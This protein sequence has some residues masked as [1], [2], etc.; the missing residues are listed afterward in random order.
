M[1]TVKTRTST[2]TAS[3][4]DR[5]LW[6]AYPIK[7]WLRCPEKIRKDTSYPPELKV[8]P[9]PAL[10]ARMEDGNIFEDAIGERFAFEADLG[11]YSLTMIDA[12]D[13]SE[14]GKR[15]IERASRAAI[16]AGVHVIWGARLT[17]RRRGLVGEPDV[18]V[19]TDWSEAASA[20]FSYYPV[21]VKHHRTMTGT[22]KAKEWRVSS[23][24]RPALADAEDVL[25]EGKPHQDDALQLAHYLPL[26]ASAGAQAPDAIGGIIGRDGQVVWMDLTQ[27]RYRR[28]TG[29]A[30]EQLNAV[31][32][33]AY[34]LDGARTAR[35]HELRRMAVGGEPLSSCEY[36]ACCAECPWREVCR[37]ELLEARHIT[38]IP[39]ITPAK[40]RAHY[41]A[42][43]T[44]F[45]DLAAL[46]HRTAVLVDAGVDLV[47]L[48]EAAK[49]V[50]ASTPVEVL[51]RSAEL[52]ALAAAGVTSA[53]D[54]ADLHVPT[55]RY[56]G[57]GVSG[58]PAAID[59][60]RARK[61]DRVLRVR[62]V[63]QLTLRRSV[64]EVD[65]DI[66]DANGVCYLIGVRESWRVGNETRRV[67][68]PFV[69][70]DPSREAQNFS[71]FWTY[72]TDLRTRV[73]SSKRGAFTAYVWSAHEERYFKHLARAYDGVPGVPTLDELE[74]LFSSPDWVD[75]LAV[76]KSDLIWPV[77]DHSVKTIAK[78]LRFMWRDT[79]PGGANSIVWYDQAIDNSDPARDEARTR[80]LAYNED[81]VDATAHVRDWLTRL[82]EARRPASKLPSAADLDV[83][84]GPAP[85]RRPASKR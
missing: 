9:S 85:R 22:A 77:E 17:D 69:T 40:A 84:Y 72:L 21:D 64:C 61:A 2:P 62:G 30:N 79:A 13:R 15:R 20:P 11:K 38:L 43:V 83:R 82:G 70:W 67:Y 42:G 47:S 19:R 23:L 31:E 81:D 1:T 6:G 35:E 25:L 53:T 71:E 26:L 3:S 48:I 55:A 50:P 49:T 76:V 44:R 8:E 24:H 32:L 33:H 12:S 7:D 27:L 16:R 36:G 14:A 39:G 68:R 46:D 65:I 51:A 75:L 58:L 52:D 66:E 10:A 28:W 73:R 4:G 5:Y 37:D 34:G 29:E 74:E 54:V 18:L 60:A 45:D 57:T 56:S 78:L 80:L 63:D 41:A 59:A